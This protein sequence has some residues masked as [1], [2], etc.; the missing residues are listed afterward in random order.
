MKKITISLIT[1]WLSSMTAF[2]QKV[3]F[4]LNVAK[5]EI[6]GQIKAYVDA[7]SKSDSIALGTLY[8]ID[9]RILNHGSPSTIGRPEI[10]KAYGEMIRDSI[11]GSS[12]ITTYLWGDNIC[13]LKKVQDTFHFQM[14]KL[15]QREDTC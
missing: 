1:I 14:A 13:L 12:F 4:D 6:Q 8:T 3:N 9:A 15:Y 5:K 7:L 11:T 10:I 2:A